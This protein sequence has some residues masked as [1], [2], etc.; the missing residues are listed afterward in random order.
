VA[1]SQLDDIQKRIQA[2]ALNPETVEISIS[3]N[4]PDAAGPK[5]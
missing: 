4:E 1:R 3:W 2:G 5:E